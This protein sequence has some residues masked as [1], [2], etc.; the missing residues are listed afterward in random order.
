MWRWV[1]PAFEDEYQ[2]VLFDYVGAGKSDCS[3]YRRDKYDSL[4]GYADDL[5]EIIDAVSR[6]PVVFIG[7]SVSAMI[8]ILAAK[9]RPQVFDRLVLIG[10][11]P[12]YLN[13][14]DYRGGYS[15]EDIEGLLESMESNYFGWASNAAAFIMG[16]ADR[17]QLA[18]ELK[19][20]FCRTDPD[21]ARQFARV[22]FFSDNREDLP[23]VD[24]PMLIM[25]C[26]NDAIAPDCIGDYVMANVPNGVFIRLR[27][28]GHCPHLSAP[29][30]TTAEIRRYLATS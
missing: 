5:L 21:I 6:T 14:G 20:S 23:D 12:C 16:N 25:Q 7:H 27:A 1:A 10:P 18:G 22:T 2:V 29:D 4:Q 13:D 30:E 3:Q 28:S 26:S 15:K 11:S 19:E 9:K 17:P 24:L 8:G